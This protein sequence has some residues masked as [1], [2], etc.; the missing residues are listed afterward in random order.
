MPFPNYQNYR[1]EELY[2]SLNH[3]DRERFPERV[4]VIKK[5][6]AAREERSKKQ[7][8]DV[9][10][11]ELPIE[12]TSKSR[13]E[14]SQFFQS[15]ENLYWKNAK[16]ILGLK[17]PWSNEKNRFLALFYLSSLLE[18]IHTALSHGRFD[19]QSLFFALIISIS[20]TRFIAAE[21]TS[22]GK[23]ILPTSKWLIL[24]SWPISIPILLF[25][26]KGFYGFLL[27]IVFTLNCVIL[28]TL[29]SILY[30]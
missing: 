26:I 1:I 30:R 6:I 7:A 13:N 9:P 12:H 20:A 19:W 16:K 21:F 4:E 23:T 24:F 25:W 14:R 10:K 17:M 2:D 18:G 11:T 3:I 27:G 5:E 28:T 15:F 29:P 22:V 8:H